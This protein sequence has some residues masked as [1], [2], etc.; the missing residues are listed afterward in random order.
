[1]NTRQHKEVK[2][3]KI[4]FKLHKIIVRKHSKYSRQFDLDKA[5]GN[6][7]VPRAILPV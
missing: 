6:S 4:Y 5:L 7:A 1:L 3:Q 2:K